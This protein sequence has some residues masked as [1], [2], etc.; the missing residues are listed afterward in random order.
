VAAAPTPEAIRALVNDSGEL[1]LRVIPGARIE[2]AAIEN[3]A[4]KLWTRTAPEDG[5]ANAAVLARIAALIKVPANAVILV[6]GHSSRDKRV[7][8]VG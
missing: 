5:K 3:G 7:R 6:Q 4:L 2:K 1:V 8:I